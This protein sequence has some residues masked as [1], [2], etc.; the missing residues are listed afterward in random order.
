VA[1]RGRLRRA[2]SVLGIAAAI[3]QTGGLALAGVLVAAAG[4]GLSFLVDGATFVVSAVTLALIPGAPAAPPRRGTLR[5]DLRDGCRVVAGR[6][7][8]SAYAAHETALNVLALSPFFVLGPV[9]AKARLG[10]APAWSAIALAYVAG[11]LAAAHVTYHWAPRRPV[12]AA[13][14]VS[15]ALAPLPALLALHAPLGLIAAAAFPAGAQSTIY[16]TLLTSTLQSN[17]PSDTLGRAAAITGIGSTVLVPVGMGL[18]GVAAGA[19]GA[20]AVL[21]AGAGC[22]LAATAVCAALPATRAPL[23]LDGVQTPSCRAPARSSG[24][25][26]PAAS[27]PTAST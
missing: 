19:V 7:W 6:P 22:V 24:R 21:L 17:L 26:R 4:P 5:Q 27:M 15:A 13:L 2:N 9:I 1:P 16:N 18:A 20:P 25:S 11:N 3:A 8:L 12:L 23:R 14:A 10:G